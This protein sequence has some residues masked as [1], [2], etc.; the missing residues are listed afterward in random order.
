MAR[1]FFLGLRE[2][3]AEEYGPGKVS[4]SQGRTFGSSNH[5]KLFLFLLFFYR[6][7]FVFLGP[8]PSKWI[9]IQSTYETLK[10]FPS[11]FPH[12]LFLLW[13]SLKK[14]L[15]SSAPKSFHTKR[16][17]VRHELGGDGVNL[18]GGADEDEGGE[19]DV[20]HGIV[21]HQHQH[22]V[23]VSAQPDVI[24]QQQTVLQIL[25]GNPNFS[26]KCFDAHDS[27]R[28]KRS[29]KTVVAKQRK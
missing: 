21:G 13:K 27:V 14:N 15:G 7:I 29:S 23:R 20:E 6:S 3:Y 11:P 26:F 2:D 19:E 16:D 4:N 8:D 5:N 28:A 12:D 18:V 22:T 10:N 9:R 24:L 17:K 1:Y 25:I